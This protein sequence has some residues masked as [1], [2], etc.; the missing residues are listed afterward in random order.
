MTETE[1]FFGEL[2]RDPRPDPMRH[3]SGSIR[4]DLRH[5]GGIGRY[6]VTIDDGSVSVSRRNAP[7]DCVVRTDEQM[8]EALARGEANA[9]TAYLRGDIELDGPPALLLAFQRLLPGPHA[10]SSVGA[11]AGGGA[12]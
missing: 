3:L 12:R 11:G 6:L 10:V 1:R 2:A 5:D 7:A 4:F 9:I 8:F